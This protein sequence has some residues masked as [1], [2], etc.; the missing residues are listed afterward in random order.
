[1]IKVVVGVGNVINGDQ[2]VPKNMVS[3]TLK[4]IGDNTETTLCILEKG[5]KLG[6]KREI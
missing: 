1:M 3:V 6:N 5:L 4:D 2:Y